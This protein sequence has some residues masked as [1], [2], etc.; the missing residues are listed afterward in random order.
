MSSPLRAEGAGAESAAAIANAPAARPATRPRIGL[1]LAGGGAKGGAHIGVLK[2]LEELHVPIDCI[3]GTSM[4][5]LV[6][7]GYASGLPAAEI[8]RFVRGVDWKAVV[9]GVGQRERESI[10]QRRNADAASAITELTVAEGGVLLPA[11]LINTGAIEDLLRG[12]VAE[13]RL[14]PDFDLLPIPFRAVATDMIKGQ[15][16]VLDHGDLAM[17]MRASMA[18]PGAF[19]PVVSDPY[20]L[21]DGFVVRNIPVDVARQTCADVVIVVKLVSPPANPQGLRSAPQLL[22]RTMDV[23]V[24]ANENAQLDTLTDR[25]VRIDVPMGDIGASDF[26]R[27]PDAIPLGEA[28]ARAVADRLARY[29]V[30]P[31]EYTAWRARVTTHQNLEVRVASVRFEGLKHVNGE[32]LRT[33]TRVKAGDVVDTQKISR[34]AL[35]LG[36][37]EGLDSVEYRLIGD[38]EHPDLVWVPKERAE[39]RNFIRPSLGIYGDGGGDLGLVVGVQ[40]VS[41]WLNERGG[42][43]RNNLELGF[44]TGILTSFYQPLDVAQTFF[45]EPSLLLERTQQPIYNDGE[46]V[47]DYKFIDAGGELDLGAE[48]AKDGQIRLGYWNQKRRTIITTGIS[49]LPESDYRDAGITATVLYDTRNEPTFSTHGF[50][51]EVDY[52]RS[53]TSM[54]ADRDWEYVEAGFRTAVPI[55]KNLMWATI[56]GGTDLGSTLPADR[57]FALGGTTFPGFQLDE[58]RMR[59]YWT[60][61]G[62]FLWR[63]VDLMPIKNN[64]VYGGFA[65]QAGRVYDRVDP[66]PNTTV[67]GG[68]VYI[69]GKTSIG[70]LTLGG[71]WA[72]QSW[73]VWLSLGRPIGNGSILD[74]SPFR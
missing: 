44:Q 11:G 22:S 28:A 6:G 13:A 66:V 61:S 33:L 72:T 7:G 47:A 37:V 73:S 54:G 8:E 51:T 39:G 49:L 43:W 2:V 56:A 67:Y 14:E 21:S 74:K 45:V 60:A 36:A 42:Q 26:E 58:L 52:R 18:I 62:S 71:A 20:I 32:Y 68:S 64:A 65:L 69:G 5:A 15:M 10:E 31:Q 24:E 1:V 27:T 40:H 16:V 50:A 57:A 53:D 30:S 17:A 55:G 41:R 59:S 25:D 63:L 19:A 70:A 4:G 48:L 46:H 29:S 9:G 3:A 12:Y 23:M 35:R 38:P 34:D